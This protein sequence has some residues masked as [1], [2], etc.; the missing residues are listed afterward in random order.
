MSEIEKE[1]FKTV[2]PLTAFN[3]RAGAFAVQASALHGVV[4]SSILDGT[5]TALIDQF[6]TVS[7]VASLLP[8]IDTAFHSQA[9]FHAR[10]A[11][12][13]ISNL[14]SSVCVDNLASIIVEKPSSWI[15]SISPSASF[16]HAEDIV[17]IAGESTESF[18][19]GITI[20]SP[21]EIHIST[22]FINPFN[23]SVLSI[24]TNFAKLSA[25]SI[26]AEGALASFRWPDLGSQIG[27]LESTKTMIGDSF[28]EL[29][30]SYSDFFTSIKVAPESI[31]QDSAFVVRQTP[32]EYYTGAEF[33]R[34]ISAPELPT[35]EKEIFNNEI[36]IENKFGLES[37]LPR[38]KPG[39]VDMWY[40]ASLALG[41]DN[42][43][44]VRH[45]STSVRELLTHV[46]H[47][48]SPDNAVKGWTSEPSHFHEGRPT[49]AARLLYICRNINLG[50][51]EKFVQKDVAATVEFLNL[52]QEGTHSIKSSL[53]EKQ[54]LALKTRTE[55]TLN[56]IIDIGSQKS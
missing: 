7:P 15:N 47:E 24:E 38:I 33:C 2:G 34:A 11:N 20:P 5:A 39:L 21:N 50:G 3:V 42:P 12:L 16:I 53:T 44:R 8:T 40:G 43:D 30:E 46:I 1:Y 37:K 49:R 19:S 17:R 55:S 32:I 13:A 14:T 41:S 26:L 25:T 35:A 54:L 29:S 9:T 22:P 27:I 48:L 45:F 36:L 23:A 31:L 52:F 10:E 18:I 51:F 6:R 4:H 28:L 56:F